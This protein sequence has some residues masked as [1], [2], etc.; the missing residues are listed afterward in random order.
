P[1]LRGRSAGAGGGT[2][3]ARHVRRSRRPRAPAG[4]GGGTVASGNAAVARSRAPGVLARRGAARPGSASGANDRSLPETRTPP[5]HGVV[6][7]SNVKRDPRHAR[8]PAALPAA[9]GSA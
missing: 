3:A 6:N 4:A 2:T 9:T 1:L 8:S 7:E 5:R